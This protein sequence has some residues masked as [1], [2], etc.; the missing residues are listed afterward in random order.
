MMLPRTE[1]TP[2]RLSAVG[3]GLVLEPPVVGTWR[4]AGSQALTEAA[5]LSHSKG[6]CIPSMDIRTPGSFGHLQETLPGV[7]CPSSHAK[8]SDSPC[9]ENCTPATVTIRLHPAGAGK[10]LS[11]LADKNALRPHGEPTSLHLTP[12]PVTTQRRGRG[13]LKHLHLHSL[14]CTTE[15][16]YSGRMYFKGNDVNW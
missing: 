11:L 4:P 14:S 16:Q 3:Q 7:Q 1:G 8:E 6:K 10:T 12:D 13:S 15:D 9:P 2:H 5:G